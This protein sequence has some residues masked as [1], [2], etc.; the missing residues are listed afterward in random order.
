MLK[1]KHWN[2]AKQVTGQHEEEHRQQEGQEA[3]G[4][5]AKDRPNGI[6]DELHRNDFDEVR[7]SPLGEV[8]IGALHF[9]PGLDG[10]GS[11]KQHNNADDARH[12]QFKHPDRQPA[13]FT[14]LHRG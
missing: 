9:V 2:Q 1:V 8:A 12:H 4:F 7:Q 13:R 14:R 6:L 10:R 3:T 5:L 11:S